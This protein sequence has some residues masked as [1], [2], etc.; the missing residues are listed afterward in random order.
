MKRIKPAPNIIKDM[1]RQKF[2]KFRNEY[3]LSHP[4]FNIIYNTQG[5]QFGVAF[6][7]LSAFLWTAIF[8][9]GPVVFTS[10]VITG[11]VG[12]FFAM[13]SHKEFDNE[14]KIMGYENQ[15]TGKD[16]FFDDG[17]LGKDFSKYE[18]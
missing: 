17:L 7:F 2:L 15:F 5:W 11:C 14:K 3:R 16:S 9:M 12:A 1:K 4:F 13:I 10:T 8:P 18:D 6:G